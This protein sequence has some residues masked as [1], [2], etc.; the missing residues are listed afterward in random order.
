MT[1]DPKDFI[2]I[3]AHE[4]LRAVY[5]SPNIEEGHKIIADL[6]AHMRIEIHELV[7]T[8]FMGADTELSVAEN[9]ALH[10]FATAAAYR[11]SADAPSTVPQIPSTTITP[12]VKQ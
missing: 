2:T 12:E 10:E 8:V 5:E 6:A 4:L 3:N 1:H 9:S 11:P 7:D